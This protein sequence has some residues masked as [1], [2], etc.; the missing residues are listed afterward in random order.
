MFKPECDSS[1]AQRIQELYWNLTVIHV[2][3]LF[4]LMVLNLNPKFFPIDILFKQS[5]NTAAKVKV[6]LLL[7]NNN[8]LHPAK[9]G[10]KKI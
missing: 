4:D 6:G 2:F 9:H 8:S 3:Y 10:V 1:L 7:Y 5:S